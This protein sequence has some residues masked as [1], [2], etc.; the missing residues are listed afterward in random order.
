[1]KN[2]PCY[3]QFIKL[4]LSTDYKG[5]VDVKMPGAIHENTFENTK[6]NS[7]RKEIA[8]FRS[9]KFQSIYFGVETHK[10]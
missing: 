9:Y 1:M 10:L 8:H 4:P 5:K 2:R 7:G 3:T 6:V